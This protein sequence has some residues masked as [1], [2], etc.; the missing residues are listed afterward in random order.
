MMINR[1]KKSLGAIAAAVFCVLAM[2]LTVFAADV[3]K[4]ELV[5]DGGEAEII[6]TFPQ[7]SAEAIASLQI[8]LRV[9][10]DSGDIRAEFI[11]DGGLAAKIVESRYH[12]DA[13]VLNIYLA[14]T[15]PLFDPSSPALVI[16]KVR[17]SSETGGAS[18]DVSVIEDS[19][20]FV[21][22]SELISPIGEIAYPD[23]V[24][25]TAE[26][27]STVVPPEPPSSGGSSGGGGFNAPPVAATAD[28]EASVTSAPTSSASESS[29]QTSASAVEVS[30]E[31]PTDTPQNT[32]QEVLVPADTSALS[33]ILARAADYKRGSY[34]DESFNALT[35]AVDKARELLSDPYALQ[36]DID[37]ALLA[38]E[39]A[40]GMLTL[41]ND[42]P[43]GGEGYGA[44]NE[45]SIAIDGGYAD[46]P[47]ISETESGNGE[48]EPSVSSETAAE[49]ATQSAAQSSDI[50]EQAAQTENTVESVFADVQPPD[51][52]APE[53]ESGSGAAAW[54]VVLTAAVVLAGAV[55]AVIIINK[56]K[57]RGDKGK[58][59]Q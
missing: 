36:E 17:I 56:K 15:E 7:A 11:P 55:T 47:S 5:P 19:V 30:A 59:S 27:G 23:T 38:L 25:L 24:R 51:S 45:V 28:S 20:K 12:S 9:T 37:E 16:G 46:G 8:A 3:Q 35:E 43:S 49:S 42:I 44:E 6:L 48:T 32:P 53:E 4:I 1:F 22:G 33:D 41:N 29:P 18:A 26:S 31:S 2:T 13:G 10:A 57:N 50:T 34:T 21:R 54:A 40:I 14:G 58:H 39:N 52:Q